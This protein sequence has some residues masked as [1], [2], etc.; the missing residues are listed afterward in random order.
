M[1]DDLRREIDRLR[2]WRHTEVVP[3]LASLRGRLKILE[4]DVA[5]LKPKVDRMAQ[6]DEIADAVRKLIWKA[7]TV[8]GGVLVGVAA[9]SAAL[10]TYL[11]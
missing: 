8:V 9:I 2:D 5:E 11:H 3:A 6:A 7:A 1:D 10:A 4:V